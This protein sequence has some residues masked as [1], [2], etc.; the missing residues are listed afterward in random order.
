MAQLLETTGTTFTADGRAVARIALTI[1]GLEWDIRKFVISTTSVLTTQCRIYRDVES[2]SALIDGTYSGN[3]D[4]SDTGVTL[5]APV[6][7]LFI[8]TGGTP[9]TQANARIEGS[10]TVRRL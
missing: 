7:L 3:Q 6:T 2:D 1:H 10:K 4:V 5:Q 8:W 9:Y